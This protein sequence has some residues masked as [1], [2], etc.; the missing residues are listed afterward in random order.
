MFL[1]L[2]PSGGTAASQQRAQGSIEGIVTRA[3]TGA[4]LAGAQV[5]LY[6]V[7]PVREAVLPGGGTRFADWREVAGS[8]YPG[9]IE[10][11]EDG[12]RIFSFTVNAVVGTQ[13][14]DVSN[15]R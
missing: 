5:R 3:D 6:M 11:Y 10:R 9:A 15:F 7:D 4:G 8:F 12:R 13:P 1:L 2:C 14:Q